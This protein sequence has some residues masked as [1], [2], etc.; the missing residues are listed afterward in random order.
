MHSSVHWGLGIIIAGITSLYISVNFWIVGLIILSSI[1]ADFDIFLRKYAQNGNH[2]MLFTHSIYLPMI[3][4]LIGFLSSKIVIIVMG[5]SYLIHILIDLL[6]WGTNA[7]FTNRIFGIRFLLKRDEHLRVPEIIDQEKIPQWFFVKRY[8]NSVIMIGI[9]VFVSI[10]MFITLF[11]YIPQFWYFLAG[12]F[13][14]MIFHISE[15]LELKH[16]SQ[17]GSPRIKL[18]KH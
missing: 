14:T 10:I 7:L 6:D 2:R 18:L 5:F 1:F 16:L 15:Y 9:E 8:Y 12:Y 3:L 4:I 13:L 11:L 17:G